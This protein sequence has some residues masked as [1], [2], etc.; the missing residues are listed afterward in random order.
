M[1]NRAQSPRGR[2]MGMTVAVLAVLMF[3][4]G[5]V[6][7][8]FKIKFRSSPKPPTVP[9][10]SKIH[11]PSPSSNLPKPQAKL[12]TGRPL[13][14]P[15]VSVAPPSRGFF[16]RFFDWLLWRRSAPAP[17]PVVPAPVA[18]PAVAARPAPA[19]P[20]VVLPV[21][22][23]A[24][25]PSPPAAQSPGPSTEGHTNSFPAQDNPPAPRIKGYILHLTNG[26]TIRTPYF[27]E[28]GGQVVIPEQ[29]G[30][31]GLSRALVARIEELREETNVVAGG[32][33]RR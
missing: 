30:S 20:P 17:A 11:V 5:P 7:A 13:P 16:Q 29:A 10:V 3:A 33:S 14:S 18:P 32:P 22:L 1:N 31:Y 6:E 8:R 4:V 12:E 23:P 2:G 28:K 19:T 27:H 25:A 15:Q 9:P 21:A 24:V 26:R